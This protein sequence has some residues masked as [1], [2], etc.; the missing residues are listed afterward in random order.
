MF[1]NQKVQTSILKGLLRMP[2]KQIKDSKVYHSEV[3]EY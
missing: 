3:L 1:H 2:S